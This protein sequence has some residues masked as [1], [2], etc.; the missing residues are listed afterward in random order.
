M[1][2]HTPHRGGVQIGVL[3]AEDFLGWKILS[4]SLFCSLK[5]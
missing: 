5:V 3:K 2:E 4:P 1:Y